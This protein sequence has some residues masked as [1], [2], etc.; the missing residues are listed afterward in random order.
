MSWG[1]AR[2]SGHTVDSSRENFCLSSPLRE[3]V[4]SA[5]A[6]NLTLELAYNLFSLLKACLNFFSYNG[7]KFE[8]TYTMNAI[9]G[10][11]DEIL[12]LSYY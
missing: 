8:A 1:I 9:Y 10:L 12:L 3:K 5:F 2:T 11:L 7:K 4:H 6:K